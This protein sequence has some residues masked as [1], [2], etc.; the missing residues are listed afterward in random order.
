MHRIC[1][2]H[3]HHSTTRS[4]SA[5]RLKSTHRIMTDRDPPSILLSLPFPTRIEER[6]TRFAVIPIPTADLARFSDKEHASVCVCVLTATCYVFYIHVKNARPENPTYTEFRSITSRGRNRSSEI[7]I[8]EC[9]F[10]FFP[11]RS[12]PRER[13]H[14]VPSRERNT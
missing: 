3:L 9:L 14:S 1:Y 13:R 10:F 11:N 8:D 7:C 2:F 5:T 4:T 6:V 12:E